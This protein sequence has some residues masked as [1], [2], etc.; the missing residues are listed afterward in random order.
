MMKETQVKIEFDVNKQKEMLL[1]T[2]NVIK[3]NMADEV[4][5]ILSF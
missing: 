5:K 4:V 3:E 1:K 2:V